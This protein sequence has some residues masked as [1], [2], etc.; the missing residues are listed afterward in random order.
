MQLRFREGSFD[1][2]RCTAFGFVGSN[3]LAVKN[4]FLELN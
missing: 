4:D 1:E 3:L 2:R